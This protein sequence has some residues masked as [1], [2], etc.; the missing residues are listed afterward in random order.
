MQAPPQTP[1]RFDPWS[2]TAPVLL[3][4]L[5]A[6]LLTLCS[7]AGL[8]GV[9]AALI[10]GSWFLK[11]AFVLLDH[12]AHGRPGM[13]VLTAEDANPLGETRPMA[14]AL[15]IGAGWGAARAMPDGYAER[16]PGDPSA[17][18]AARLGE[19]IERR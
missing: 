2:W 7:H 15:L 11:Y 17:A 4:V 16:Y 10:V 14:Y 6:T 1:R 13:P 9:P 3:V 19:E 12:V 8:L 5:F 18:V